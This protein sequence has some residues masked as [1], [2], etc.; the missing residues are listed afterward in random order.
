[1]SLTVP[2]QTTTDGVQYA[3]STKT[4]SEEKLDEPPILEDPYATVD[5]EKVNLY[6]TNILAYSE[7]SALL[8]VL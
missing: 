7:F 3:V 5:K 1:M 4:A 6:L 8:N 2:Q